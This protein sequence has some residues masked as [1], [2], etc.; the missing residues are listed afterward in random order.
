MACY[1]RAIKLSTEIEFPQGM[2]RPYTHIGAHRR[3]NAD[4]QTALTYYQKALR[5]SEQVE[6]QENIIFGLCNVGWA[7]Y[8]LE[9]DFKMAITRFTRALEIA[10]GLGF[11]FAIGRAH[12]ALAELFWEQGDSAQ[13]LIHFEKL[14]QLADSVNYKML[15][16]TA[17]QRIA[18]IKV[19]KG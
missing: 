16:E 6:D 12:H 18:E 1:E 17:E 19:Q 4:L 7:T 2:I 15:S 9:R 10:E 14:Y 5:I 11:R 8:R 13:A 3:R